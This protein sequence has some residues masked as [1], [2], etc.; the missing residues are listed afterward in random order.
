M[1]NLEKIT[2]GGVTYDLRDASAVHTVDSAMSSSSTDPV[3]NKV[4]KAYVD[5]AIQN[6]PYM[7]LAIASNFQ[8]AFLVLQNFKNLPTT[9]ED[10]VADD[11]FKMALAR[12]IIVDVGVFG[13]P[14]V[15]G[16]VINMDGIQRTNLWT[17]VFPDGIAF[18]G[19]LLNGVSGY[20]TY[21]SFDDVWYLDNFSPNIPEFKHY[22]DN[23]I[24]TLQSSLNYMA[25]G[26]DA[27]K[28]ITVAEQS[29]GL[30]DVSAE[31]IAIVST[32][33]KAN[34]T[35][36]ATP[37]NGDGL[38]FAD[39]DDANK[40]KRM[41]NGFGTSTTTFLRND[42]T[43]AAPPSGEAP[44]AR[45]FHGKCSTAASTAAKV[46]TCP[47]FL[48]SDFVTGAIVF[49]T[50]TATNSAAVASITLNVNGTGAKNIKYMRNAAESNLPGT[51]YLRA[52]MT[53]RFVYNGTYW[54][55]DTDYD[56]D[57]VTMLTYRTFR[58]ASD[59]GGSLYSYKLCA[60]DNNGDLIPFNFVSS[61]PT[62]VY[63][64]AITTHSF[65]PFRGF[66]YYSGTTTTSAGSGRDANEFRSAVQF[67]C[68]YS[69]NIDSSGTAGS[70][71]LTAYDPVYIKALYTASTRLAKLV[72]DTSNSNYLVRS[73]VVQV[74]P[75]ADPNTGLTD[76]TFYIYILLGQ[77]YSKYQIDMFDNKI[78]YYWNTK[79]GMMTEFTGIIEA[80]Y[81]TPAD[82]STAINALDASAT[83]LSASKTITALLE[84]NGVISA[85]ASDIAIDAS[86][87]AAGTFASNRIYSDA[88]MATA[89]ESGDSVIFADSNDSNKL[90]RMSNGFDT[91]KTTEFLRRDGTWQVPSGG[92]GTVTGSGIGGYLAKWTGTSGQTA[93]ELTVGP[94]IGTGTT[95]YLRED[96]TW[97]EVGGGVEPVEDTD[98]FLSRSVNFGANKYKFPSLVGGTVAWNQLAALVASSWT[99]SSSVS[100]SIT[101]K[102]IRLTSTSAT[103]SVK[104]ASLPVVANHVYLSSGTVVSSTTT[105]SRFGFFDSAGTALKIFDNNTSQTTPKTGS[106]LYKPT[107][108]TNVYAL[109]LAN[110][111]AANVYADFTNI[112]LIDLTVALGSTIADYIYSLE[113]ATAGAGVNWFKQ[114]FPKSYYPYNAGALVSVN[115]TG[116]QSGG[117]KTN[118]VPKSAPYSKTP[119]TGTTSYNS[120]TNTV[121]FSFT[122]PSTGYGYI[123]YL[124]G[125]AI[126]LD[127]KYYMGAKITGTGFTGVWFKPS[128]NGATPPTANLGDNNYG[129][130]Q[131]ASTQAYTLVGLNA[132]SGTAVTGYIKDI[133][134]VDLTIELG[135]T[136]A[137]EI[138]ALEQA[139]TGKGIE[140][141]RQIGFFD[142]HTYSISPVELR[143]I[144]KLSDG[145]LAFDGD[146]RAS[147]GTVTR[148]Y[149]IVDM[150]TLLYNAASTNVSGKNRFISTTAIGVP[151]AASAIANVICTKYVAKTGN[152]LCMNETGI[153]MTSNGSVVIY[154]E[155]YASGTASAFVAAMSG[156]Y[157]VYELDTPT[158]ES[159][160]ALP[161]PQ[162]VYDN[163]IE[164]YIDERD[165]QMPV[166]QNATYMDATS[167]IGE[168]MDS[169]LVPSTSGPME[170]SGTCTLTDGMS[171]SFTA[172]YYKIGRQVT[173]WGTIPKYASSALALS[174]LP[175]TPNATMS[176]VIQFQQDGTGTARV[177]ATVGVTSGYTALNTY[178]YITGSSNNGTFVSNA[179]TWLNLIPSAG[180][181]F[182]FTYI[183]DVP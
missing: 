75:T 57:T 119:T 41:T 168:L 87:V 164:C 165:A 56:A 23:A 130:I 153:T 68:R 67:D 136:L 180:L 74:L 134:C 32:Q 55:C 143:G 72:A 20:L 33:V 131:N 79:A 42:G 52:N 27:S 160:A 151:T 19:T 163:G 88:T 97:A 148:K 145:K 178:G 149:G 66:L 132:S 112:Q 150:G 159:S 106:I 25:S 58:V 45:I 26:L 179:G 104:H 84:T 34:A 105:T 174:G 62:T 60:L 36:A 43:W 158:T 37:A 14:V 98:V 142:P 135:E 9:Y 70:T 1:A 141:L 15:Q 59:A 8:N 115:P 125:D 76:G 167:A 47:Q 176:S 109:R 16:L 13:N 44:V 63:T 5:D 83:G 128:S 49:V 139:T 110:A 173:I 64:K 124:S 129:S 171:I 172:N 93:T 113:T 133:V 117:Y 103:S 61:S 6:E 3:Q 123:Q 182:S 90:K 12:P 100:I 31:D 39:S 86:Q 127:H 175:Y 155:T 156:V 48:A 28:T 157:L 96:G 154:D 22:T 108:S 71:A 146:V 170:G 38:I 99:K 10:L 81:A 11:D 140:R 120:E 73:S 183:T 35:E 126:V 95:K 181:A 46:V 30:L 101:G 166:G 122:S 4:V 54:V 121:T 40:L 85:S 69:L 177:D 118:I 82:I 80:D 94:M 107:A 65:N 147:D 53:Y 102:T 18:N 162:V 111:A 78:V 92:S 144:P 2:A 89:I 24:T 91:T 137:N 51:S 50:F 29:D 114:Y 7:R 17:I 138:Y 21:D 152:A 77:A 169:G 161:V 116:A